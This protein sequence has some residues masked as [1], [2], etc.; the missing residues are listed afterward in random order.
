M[1]AVGAQ[2]YK[3]KRLPLARVGLAPPPENENALGVRKVY[4]AASNN[5]AIARCSRDLGALEVDF[6]T[7]SAAP[8]SPAP[9]WPWCGES[10]ARDGVLSSAQSP[11][12]P[13]LLHVAAVSPSMLCISCL[14]CVFLVF[15]RSRA[16][17][18]LC[19][20]SLS[21]RKNIA[22]WRQRVKNSV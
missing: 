7:M 4:L 16:L 11:P 19:T 8:F 1:E 22:L 12:P 5:L 18:V 3:R 2:K 20:F 17:S 21:P 10:S 13:R 15:F 9:W 14:P 6:V